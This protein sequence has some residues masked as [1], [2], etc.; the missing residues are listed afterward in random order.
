MDEHLVL[1]NQLRII[2]LFVIKI[3][4]FW[5]LCTNTIF[6][7]FLLSLLSYQIFLCPPIPSQVYD[8]FFLNYYVIHTLT[9]MYW[10]HFV[11]LMNLCALALRLIMKGQQPMIACS[12]PSK[13]W[14]FRDFFHPYCDVKWWCRNSGFFL[15]SHSLKFHWC[16]FSTMSRKHCLT[17][18]VLV[19]WTLQSSGPSFTMFPEP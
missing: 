10:I 11:L 12:Y 1:N 8:L 7:Q 4:N 13:D 16:S 5:V 15:G 18:S 3:F 9:H 17:E 6:T 19:L 2:Y 14:I